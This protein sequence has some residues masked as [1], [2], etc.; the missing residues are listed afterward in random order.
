MPILRLAGKASTR[1]RPVNSALGRAMNTF[2]TSIIALTLGVALAAIASALFSFFEAQAMFELAVRSQGGNPLE[3][4]AV[5]FA[6]RGLPL[7]L[8]S[9]AIGLLAL[10]LSNLRNYFLLGLLST[11]WLLWLVGV[12][13]AECIAVSMSP[14]CWLDYRPILMLLTPILAVLLGVVI[15]GI[16][17]KRKFL[18]GAAS[19]ETPPK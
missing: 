10:R 8:L 2:R 14:T 13:T 1:C 15:A 3:G 17:K 11:P 18:S 9:V 12:S 19:Q 6:I 4:A 7:T 16:M 5:Y